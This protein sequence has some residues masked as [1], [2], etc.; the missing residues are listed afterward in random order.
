MTGMLWAMH[1]FPEFE[2]LDVIEAVRA[3]LDPLF[4]LIP[5]HLTLVF[6]FEA[7]KGAVRTAMER[8]RGVISQFAGFEL[9][10]RRVERRGEYLMLLPERGGEEVRALHDALYAGAFARWYAPEFPYTPHVTLGR[11]DFAFAREDLGRSFVCA[12]R[13]VALE[14]IGADGSSEIMERIPLKN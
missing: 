13:Q 3:E 1:V 5:P 11:G 10:M 7:E 2:G 9:E 14:R 4:G 8:A 6:P 12:V